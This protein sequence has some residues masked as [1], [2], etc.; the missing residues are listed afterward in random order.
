MALPPVQLLVYDR[1]GSMA[2]CAKK[3]EELSQLKC[4][5]IVK[6]HAYRHGKNASAIR[7]SWI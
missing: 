7:V 6:F 4:Y 2:P 1:A 3:E 5:I